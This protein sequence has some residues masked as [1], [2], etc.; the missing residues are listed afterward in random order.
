MRLLWAISTI[1]AMSSS[2]LA[3]PAK[4]NDEDEERRDA[5]K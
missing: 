2:A 4:D 1:I 3:H 5:N